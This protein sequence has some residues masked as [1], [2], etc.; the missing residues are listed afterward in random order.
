MTTYGSRAD[1]LADVGWGVFIHYLTSVDATA[2]AWNAVVESFDVGRLAAQV[3]RVG[4]GYCVVTIGQ[5]SGH[6]CAP[7]ATYDQVVGAEKSKCSHRD[8]V[9][10][11]A[12][13]LRSEGV[14]LL[15]YLPVH[16]PAHDQHACARF[17]WPWG[18][19]TRRPG[20][21][22]WLPESVKPGERLA[23]F[24]VR[25]EAVIGEWSLRWAEGI[26]GWWF[27]GC[28]YAGQMYRYADA[29]N[30][31]S[32]AAAARAGNERSILAFN[33]GVRVPVI[34]VTEH[35]D[36]TAGEISTAFPVCP[37]PRVGGARWHV[38]TFLGA[39]WGQGSPRF[40]PEFVA[41]YTSDVIHKGGAVTWD[42]PI[43]SDGAIPEPFLLQLETLQRHR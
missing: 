26:A 20:E 32:L 42:V 13:V 5:N 25:W 18:T 39:R 29:P 33:P 43:T 3:Q 28:Y 9:A 14:R 1:W 24:Q 15:V 38:L 22:P 31:A 8:L 34:S 16:P 2:A 4:A 7:N 41:G 11:L 19:A 17:G 36:Y 30:F 37:G 35:E 27:D 21:G 10:D 6:Y 40:V 12:A 23:E